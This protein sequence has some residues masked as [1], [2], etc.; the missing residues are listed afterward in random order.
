MVFPTIE[1]VTLRSDPLS[2]LV[3]FP[4]V[5]IVSAHLL[6]EKGIFPQ[7][8]DRAM[9]FA[10]KQMDYKIVARILLHPQF[11]STILADPFSLWKKYFDT[12][13]LKKAIHEAT[14]TDL[15]S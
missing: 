15:R 1:P 10:L 4:N 3:L 5:L 11:E 2:L 9:I 6:L 14:R 12:Q 7:N 13:V 8:Y